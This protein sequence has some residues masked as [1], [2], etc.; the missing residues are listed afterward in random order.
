MKKTK[1]NGTDLGRCYYDWFHGVHYC[2][3]P[4]HGIRRNRTGTVHGY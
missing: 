2:R 4:E 1:K 3:M